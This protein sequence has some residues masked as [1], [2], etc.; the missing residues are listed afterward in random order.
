MALISLP[1][2]ILHRIV[3]LLL[4][5]RIKNTYCRTVS[6]HGRLARW[7][8]WR[9]CDVGQAKEELGNELWRRW[10]NGRVGEWAVTWVK[11]W[12]RCRMS[13][14]VGGVTGSRAHSPTFPWLHLRHSSFS[15]GSVAL[16]TSQLILQLSVTSPTSQLILQ[17]FRRFTYVAAHSPTLHSLYLHHSSFSNPSFASPTSQALHLIHLA[18]RPCWGLHVWVS[19]TPQGFD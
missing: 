18:S 2:C 8:K 12:K 9:A 17:P 14:D 1:L 13:C 15:N 11:R 10:N 6:V 5:N 7:R 16:P 19:V 3:S 4:A